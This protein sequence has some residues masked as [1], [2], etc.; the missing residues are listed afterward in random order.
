M[1]DSI[2]PHLL[3]RLAPTPDDRDYQLED[4][5][6]SSSADPLDD[7]LAKLE[8]SH[9]VAAATK[10]WAVEAT[11][12]IKAV[13]PPAPAPTPPPSPTPTG[14]VVWEN[15]HGRL[16]QGQYGTCVGNGWSNL[17]NTKA[18]AVSSPLAYDEG[19]FGVEGEATG[20]A[21]HA[22]AVYYE[23]TVYDGSPDD[24]DAPGGG[25]QGSQVRSGAK[26]ILK[27]GGI[28]GYAFTT[29]QASIE[30]FLQTKGSMVVGSDWT[31]DMFNP[32]ASG[33][34]KPTGG[35][36]GGHCY[37]LVGDLQS[38]DAFLF[39]NSWGEGWGL[40]G[41]FKM[42]KSDFMSLIANGGEVCAPVEVA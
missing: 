13:S 24:P 6:E 15:P 4:Y 20:G 42:K 32:D 38:E 17:V 14:D 10:H 2:G 26:A 9:S 1:P 12:R 34:V 3:G 5:L 25:Q 39:E 40:K 7:L 22:R 36:A 11:A 18:A 8:A 21:N 31:N 23:A 19:P 27:R 35:V 29:S 28:S 41:Y 33:Y 37:H 30:K 16:D